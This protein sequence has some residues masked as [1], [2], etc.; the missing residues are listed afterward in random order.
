MTGYAATESYLTNLPSA[1]DTG[2]WALCGRWLVL[3]E[4]KYAAGAMIVDAVV[5]LRNVLVLVAILGT[6]SRQ[7]EAAILAVVAGFIHS[8]R[9]TTRRKK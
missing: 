1:P 3:A 8:F 7:Q 4:F 2:L 5:G 6:L 9:I